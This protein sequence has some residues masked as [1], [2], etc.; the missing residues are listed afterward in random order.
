MPDSTLAQACFQTAA[1]ALAGWNAAGDLLARR[2]VELADDDRTAEE[3]WPS[4][5][6]DPVYWRCVTAG[7]WGL[8]SAAHTAMAC[9]LT[10]KGM[11]VRGE[12]LFQMIR[13]F[14]DTGSREVADELMAE[15]RAI[16]AEIAAAL[17]PGLRAHDRGDFA[18]AL[19]VYDD[20][21]ARWP[22]AGWPR[23]ERGLTLSV[24]DVSRAWEGFESHAAQLKGDAPVPEGLT[25]VKFDGIKEAYNSHL[26]A[27][28]R[29]PFYMKALRVTQ[30]DIVQVMVRDVLTVL[31]GWGVPGHVARLAEVAENLDP[32]TAAHAALQLECHNVPFRRRR[33]L[34]SSIVTL[35]VVE[36]RAV[37]EFLRPLDRSEPAPGSPSASD[38]RAT[39]GQRLTGGE[40]D[41]L[42][43]EADSLSAAGKAAEAGA[44]AERVLQKNRFDVGP[45][46][47]ARA[48]CLVGAGHLARS[49]FQPAIGRLREAVEAAAAD[50]G[51]L[52]A[53]RAL[54]RY[55]LA[56]AQSAAGKP[57]EARRELIEAAEL[58]SLAR[59]ADP[60]VKAR[61]GLL[62]ASV[63][64]RL[65]NL[66]SAISALRETGDFIN[67]TEAQLAEPVRR[68]L[69]AEGDR[70]T[71]EA[72]SQ[73]GS[74]E[75]AVTWLRK[76]LG[77]EEHVWGAG[78][79]RTYLTEAR[80]GV[81]LART[82][83]PDE[84][85]RL[86]EASLAK[87]LTLFGPG[88]PQAAEE[89]FLMAQLCHECRDDA[90][91]AGYYRDCLMIWRPILQTTHPSLND[92]LAG[93]G[94]SQAA[95]GDH[96]T[97]VQSLDEAIRGSYARLV[98]ASSASVDDLTRLHAEHSWTSDMLAAIALRPAAPSSLSAVAG[99]ALVNTKSVA[100][101]ITAGRRA[102][103]GAAALHTDLAILAMRYAALAVRGPRALSSGDYA[104]EILAMDARLAQESGWGAAGEETDPLPYLT[105][106]QIAGQLPVAAAFVAISVV[107]PW[108]PDGTALPGAG[109]RY[110][111]T[112]VNT[113]GDVTL[114]LLGA[115]VE[116]D[117]LVSRF[118]EEM[119]VFPLLPS[120][121]AV[122]SSSRDMV[123]GIGRQ[124][125]DLILRPVES[126]LES[127]DHVI[128]MLDGPLAQLPFGCLVDG[129]DRFAAER[130]MLTYISGIHDLHPLPTTSP[131][132]GVIVLANPDF[133]LALQGAFP[134][135]P[136][137]EGIAPL[138][139]ALAIPWPALNGTT[140]ELERITT[141]VG[142]QIVSPIT[143]PDA[144]KGALLTLR[145]PRVLHVATHAYYVP[146]IPLT[147][148]PG[149]SLAAKT[150]RWLKA[151]PLVRSGL[152]LAGAN[153]RR[154]LPVMAPDDGILTALEI[155]TVFDLTATRLVVLSACQT[156]T[157]DPVSGDSVHGV[158]RA[159]HIAGAQ[160]VIASLWAVPDDSAADL[161]ADLYAE[162]AKGASPA[163]AM[164][165][166][167]LSAM[168]R[169]RDADGSMPH[170]FWWAAYTLSGGMEAVVR[171][172][173][174]A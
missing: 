91:A 164:H 123:T 26:A 170:P 13:P 41:A 117:P 133:G 118:R 44:V 174:L 5:T 8:A 101:G 108:R 46:A 98:T 30:G 127:C 105:V 148:V 36:D 42:L 49:E 73:L 51:A 131:E 61:V 96:A 129:Q 22:C 122:A 75:Q 160:A 9:L 97:A 74:S 119:T 124:L 128:L 143:G 139:D 33:V 3:W 114:H 171:P 147:V 81:A 12:H 58:L 113:A 70:A 121:P 10:V 155:G 21:I 53:G 125:Y 136:T 24:A 167:T 78:H 40:I 140:L 77:H 54:I 168:D 161:V 166:A 69:I 120:V 38:P 106:E 137:P 60:E 72:L 163:R 63:E 82:G 23:Y 112:V 62:R 150:D 27:L 138:S 56:G 31:T 104:G 135:T 154:L 19:R 34:E 45:E 15:G 52:A 156:G 159:C 71:A 48:A 85:R 145:K 90:A 20:V 141:A 116:I 2:L 162:F 79:P 153:A 68:L 7:R 89:Y 43:A 115:V 169:A 66:Q 25:V 92:A 130:W 134:E 102:R 1:S 103:R 80:L 146:E 100:T 29:D 157:G 95:L 84:G 109:Q 16:G 111:A 35:G 132:T 99:A 86:L 165:C 17:E 28:L 65:G 88:S 6:S 39:G 83:S 14:L 11:T 149:D 151:S 59:E 4:L 76:A 18:A 93:L 158:R 50:A 172:D 55:R 94:V 144:S 47:W 142:E 87:C 32:W 64:T 126:A 152:V 107:Q 37:W 173:P 67:T 110:L 57:T